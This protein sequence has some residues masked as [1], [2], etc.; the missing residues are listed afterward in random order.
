[1]ISHF[2]IEDLLDT[3]PKHK[4]QE[5]TYLIGN[6]RKCIDDLVYDKYRERL[7]YNTYWGKRDEE[8]LQHL[9]DNYGVGTPI[10]IPNMRLMA[11]RINRMIGKALQNHLDYH[12]T[13]SNSKAIDLKMQQKKNQMLQ[14]IDNQ[15]SK[16]V[17][18]NKKILSN[19]KDEEGQP[20]PVQDI[21]NEKFLKDLRMKYGESWQADFEIAVQDF[22][23]HIID[24]KDFHKKN[25]DW[26]RDLTV[27]GQEFTRTFI[28][29]ENKLPEIWHVDPENFFY[30]HNPNSPWI[31]DCRRVVY[32]RYMNPTDVLNELGHLLEKD[33][34][35]KIARAI[36]T[37]YNERHSREML[38]E[39]DTQGHTRA[40]TRAPRYEGDLVAVYHV[41]WI[42]VNDE[43]LPTNSV[44]LVE[45]KKANIKFKKR[46]RKDRYEG[47]F[48]DIAGGIYCGMGKS[49]HIL[50][51]QDDPTDCKLSYNGI[52]YGKHR[53][54][55]NFDSTYRTVHD[56]PF[57]LVLATKDL[58]DLYDITHF[59]LNNLLAAARPGGTITVLEHIPN[60]WGDTPEERFL[61]STAYEK[62][63]S[64]KIISI[65][66][67]GMNPNEPG[68][69]PFNNY[70]SYPANLDGQLVQSF[71]AY[72][73]N[74]EQQADRM[75]GLNPQM[76][77][78]VEE[79]SGKGVTTQAI[80]QA[81]LL[82]KEIFR[83][84]SLFIRKI[85]TNLANL[86]KL[87]FPDGYFGA[88][89]K[90]ENHRVF[91]LLGTESLLADYDVF[92]T[93]DYEESVELAKADEIAMAAISSGAASIKTSLDVLLSRSVSSKKRALERAE[94]EVNQGAAQQLQETQTQLEELQK[95][96]DTLQ[97]EN[98]KLK[99]KKEQESARLQEVEIKK[100]QLEFEKLK[101]ERE[102]QLKE[103]SQD[104]KYDIEKKELQAEILQLQDM[105]AKNDKINKNR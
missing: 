80:Q 86:S 73:D 103:K 38:F 5:S 17:A 71:I 66:Q 63:L 93:D 57:S 67:Q 8:Q 81:E 45:S 58:Q 31:E 78:E 102:M 4:K 51:S 35:S 30:E 65:S 52:V 76:M 9:A 90:G 15:I 100:K 68:S 62:N 54:R 79:R 84:H 32:R 69:I 87:A 22:I 105:N 64:Q 77:G 20:L 70:G 92:V 83:V 6:V 27:T 26:F 72:I 7:A 1:M 104:E 89:V 55:G 33:D 16:V 18:E 36:N 95:Q 74:L 34:H 14:E 96:L 40:I 61:T 29:E 47:Y 82:T 99:S 25:G 44:D 39:E 46:K 94:Q 50:R 101:H 13:C 56:E 91:Q 41:E 48:I 43:E 24:K 2:L 37:Y 42:S 53:S 88:Y 10:D 3:V 12:V 23:E 59:H 11:R 49:K 19:L 28:R 98:E 97:K 60:V 85:L 21:I 75:L